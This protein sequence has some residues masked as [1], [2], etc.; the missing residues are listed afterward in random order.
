METS[1]AATDT[2][3]VVMALDVPLAA[4][5]RPIQRA[6][7]DNCETEMPWWFHRCE[8][9]LED[10]RAYQEDNDDMRERISARKDDR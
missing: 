3:Q 2:G 10:L 8:M 5:L 1:S 4:D 6:D 9:W 7:R